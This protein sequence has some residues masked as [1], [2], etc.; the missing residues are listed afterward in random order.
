MAAN[1]PDEASTEALAAR[2]EAA[3]TTVRRQAREL[4]ELRAQVPDDTFADQLRQALVRMGAAGQVAAP[5]D[6]ND[7]LDLIVG[8]AARVIDAQAAS[9]YL[10]DRATNELV[11]VV[12]LGESAAKAR[13]FRV[14]VGTGI[15]GWVAQT[16]EPAL[17]ADASQDPRFAANMAQSIG[18]IPR[19]VLCLP[20]RSQESLIGV[21]QA[22]DRAG[23][24]PFTENDQALLTEFAAEAAV[25]IEQSR[26]V[27]DLARL[28]LVV[29]HQMFPEA[30]LDDERV[31]TL[32]AHAAEFA[33]R[34]AES[35]QYRE[36][37]KI[38]ALVNQVSAQ[39]PEARHLCQE[40]LT[41][42]A[43]YVRGQPSD[44]AARGWTR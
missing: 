3:E 12:A 28:F 26:I 11:F 23:G 20:M 24:Q 18:Y 6:H 2:L 9:L 37:L 35:E 16:G 40:I 27:R 5:V 21:I 43:T 14:P 17:I 7:L 15:A 13:Q 36:A 41:G 1:P 10:I 25:A 29:L 8:T 34:V 31:R 44:S 42:V 4:V 19:S 32:A 38:T 39:G 30:S 33:T 22:F